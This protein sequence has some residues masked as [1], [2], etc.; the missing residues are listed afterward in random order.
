MCSRVL[1]AQKWSRPGRV[2]AGCDTR[3]LGLHAAHVGGVQEG[4]AVPR[5]GQGWRDVG[6]RH[7]VFNIRLASRMPSKHNETSR[8]S[9]CPSGHRSS[10][11]TRR[12]SDR[13]RAETG[14]CECLELSH[15]YLLCVFWRAN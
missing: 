12:S 10:L 14:L 5:S 13:T 11:S 8:V 7:L 1:G 2:G 9:I 3:V 15:I 6:R 4:S